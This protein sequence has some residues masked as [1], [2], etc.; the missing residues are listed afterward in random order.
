M[1]CQRCRFHCA[2]AFSPRSTARPA[3]LWQLN[4][5]ARNS[6]HKWPG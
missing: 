3:G 1:A 5:I 4:P 2:T 6:F